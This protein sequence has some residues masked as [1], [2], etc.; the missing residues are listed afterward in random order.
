VRTGNGAYSQSQ[1]DLYGYL[2]EAALAYRMLGGRLSRS[3]KRDYARVADF[4]A[5]CWEEPDLGL[6]EIRSEPRHFVHSKAMCWVVLDRSIR[7]IGKRPKWLEL[8]DRIWQEIL[9]RGRAPEGHF[10]QSFGSSELDASLLQLA[11]IGAPIDAAT[12]AATRIAAERALRRGDFMYRYTCEDGLSG[13]EGAFLVCSFWLVDAL[14]VEGRIDEA[15]PLFERLCERA[16][17]V[18][19]FSEQL[20]PDSGAFLGNFPQAFTHVGLIAAAVNLRLFESHGARALRGS[21]GERARRSVRATLGWKGALAG[22]RHAR[23]LKINSSQASMLTWLE[24]G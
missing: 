14:L 15:L 13:P 19:L 20:D 11:M 21:Y 18:G 2:L 17:D 4:I 12:L 10:V 22:L 8:R 7:L 16:N 9:A 5:G 6:W 23:K 3:A 1:T 24:A